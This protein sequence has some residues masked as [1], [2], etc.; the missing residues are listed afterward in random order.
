MRSKFRIIHHNVLC[1]VLG[2]VRN[3]ITSKLS[4]KSMDPC[5]YMEVKKPQR[6]GGG[7]NQRH[8]EQRGLESSLQILISRLRT[9]S[10]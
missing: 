5:D 6:R 7:G 10:F 2:Q 8:Q 4:S 1:T 3:K 9:C